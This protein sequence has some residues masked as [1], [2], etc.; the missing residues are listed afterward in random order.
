MMILVMVMVMLTTLCDA[1]Y[2]IA[3]Q[4]LKAG[5]DVVAMVVNEGANNLLIG[6]RPI[7]LSIIIS[8]F[9]Y[10]CFKYLDLSI[11]GLHVSRPIYL[12][13]PSIY[14]SI[15]PS[16]YLSIHVQE[17]STYSST[18][19]ARVACMTSASRTSS[20]SLAVCKGPVHLCVCL[21]R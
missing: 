4:G 18:S 19:P 7:Y 10:I 14:S 15:H 9:I 12:C 1:L 13:S 8:L 20:S 16:T 3:L 21:S 5:D 6:L 2:R 17:R 11:Y